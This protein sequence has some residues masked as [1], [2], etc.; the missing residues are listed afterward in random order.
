MCFWGHLI[1]DT[2]FVVSE[3]KKIDTDT[4]QKKCVKKAKVHNRFVTE[5]PFAALE[6]IS[7]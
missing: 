3:K 5:I 7:H 6:N 4:R 2:F 1:Q